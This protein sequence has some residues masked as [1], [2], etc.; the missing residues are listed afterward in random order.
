[1][2]GVDLLP[3]ARRRF[4]PHRHQRVRKT[5]A[6]YYA[7][8]SIDRHH[9]SLIQ[10]QHPQINT[11]KTCTVVAMSSCCAAS[12]VTGPIDATTVVLSRS[13]ACSPPSIVTKFLTAN[14][15]AWEASMS[16]CDETD[17]LRPPFSFDTRFMPVASGHIV[18]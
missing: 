6:Y 11:G 3:L 1:L 13:P 17:C 10:L 15:L 7:G 4:D 14:A 8:A 16:L 9:H 2:L 18:Q 5:M 12:A